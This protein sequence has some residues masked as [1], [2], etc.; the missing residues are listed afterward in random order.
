MVGTD[1]TGGGPEE[2]DVLMY[3]ENRVY[4]YKE[5]VIRF[6]P[7]PFEEEIIFWETK[8]GLFCNKRRYLGEDDESQ[9]CE[10]WLVNPKKVD[11]TFQH[12][13]NEALH[14]YEYEYSYSYRSLAQKKGT[15][16]GLLE[17]CK[18]KGQVSEEDMESAE[19][20]LRSLGGLWVS[21]EKEEEEAYISILKAYRKGG[22][23]TIGYW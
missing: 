23:E 17:T 8:Q 20:A 19:K 18:T 1:N 2:F 10:C 11:E 12:K 16:Q 9:E 7:D 4:N 15:L 22:F 21:D 14:E 6:H 13:M 5:V 3:K